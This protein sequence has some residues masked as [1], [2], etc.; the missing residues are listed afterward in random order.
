MTAFFEQVWQDHETDLEE[1]MAGS[2]KLLPM[3][4]PVNGRP[5]PDPD[6][7]ETSFLGIID[8]EFPEAKL[9][10]HE[11]TSRIR[12]YG[13]VTVLHARLS[14]LK[15]VKLEEGDLII[16]ED[17]AGKPRYLVS[18]VYPDGLSWFYAELTQVGKTA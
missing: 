12:R 9:P 17:R 14:Q 7:P 13:N 16:N 6:R 1:V 8:E 2:V 10:G 4:K 15:G 18:R 5:N 11:V 3:L